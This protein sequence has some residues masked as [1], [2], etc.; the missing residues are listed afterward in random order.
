MQRHDSSPH[1]RPGD[2]SLTIHLPASHPPPEAQQSW[3]PPGDQNCIKKMLLE[4]FIS[5]NLHLTPQPCFGAWGDLSEQDANS[6]GLERTQRKSHIH[7][8]SWAIYYPESLGVP[9]R[10]GPASPPAAQPSFQFRDLG[11]KREN[12]ISE[13]RRDLQMKS[14]F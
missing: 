10:N 3:K 2:S 1:T 11:V 7:T 8:A 4:W 12:E 13:R 5:V 9:V 6:E 14:S